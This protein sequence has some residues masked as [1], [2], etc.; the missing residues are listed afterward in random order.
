MTTQR[1]VEANRENARRSTGP[2]T[3]E[4]KSLISKNATT[5]G[6]TS[7]TTVLPDED[8]DLFK[9]LADL[10]REELKPVGM[11]EA[12]L[13]DRVISKIWRL[14]RITNIETGIYRSEFHADPIE[15][16]RTELE[17]CENQPLDPLLYVSDQKRYEDANERVRDLKA[18][19]DEDMAICAHG[20]IRDAQGKELIEKLAKYETSAENSLSRTLAEL[21]LSQESRLRTS[22]AT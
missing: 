4:G 17:K 14:A 13:V 18:A 11:I 9:K 10:L 15:Q 21:R 5:H 3:D 6:I 2:R 7:T 12:V 8:A 1:Q 19:R 22:S 20:F 16:A